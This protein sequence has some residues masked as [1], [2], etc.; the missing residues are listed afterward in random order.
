MA[1]PAAASSDWSDPSLTSGDDSARTC[2]QCGSMKL[3][4]RYCTEC[5]AELVPP[6]TVTHA[7]GPMWAVNG[8][9][10]TVSPE[11][12]LRRTILDAVARVVNATAAQ[13]LRATTL[14][15]GQAR[16]YSPWPRRGHGRR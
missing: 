15:H 2:P 4:T 13:S 12:D 8:H 6:V 9:V 1:T 11:E 3:G 7:V 16:A 10:L 14:R 5:A